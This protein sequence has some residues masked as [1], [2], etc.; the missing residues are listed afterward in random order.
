MA[1]EKSESSA[2]RVVDRRSFTSEGERNP[3]QEEHAQQTEPQKQAP[4]EQAPAADAGPESDLSEESSGFATLVSY[5]SSTALYQLGML[6]GPGGE[7]L[8]P[9]LLNGRRTIGLL[10]VLEEKT[11]GNLSKGEAKLL[12]DVLYEL[13]LSFVEV[14][15]QRVSNRK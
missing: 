5:L 2:F 12:D 1:E 14:Q 9:D 13:R 6:P 8:P 7:T 3:G 4:R 15:K 11:R 10:E